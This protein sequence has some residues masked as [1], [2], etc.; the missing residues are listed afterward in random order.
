MSKLTPAVTT[1][2]LYY[3]WHFRRRNRIYIL[4]ERPKPRPPSWKHEYR[5][6]QELILKKFDKHSKIHMCETHGTARTKADK[7]L[8]Q[9]LK[10]QE[11]IY[12]EIVVNFALSFFDHFTNATFN[13]RHDWRNDGY[14]TNQLVYR[15]AFLRKHHILLP[16]PMI[17]KS[18][19]LVADV[20]TNLMPL[21]IVRSI[22]WNGL[23][24]NIASVLLLSATDKRPSAVNDGG[25]CCGGLKT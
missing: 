21:K 5:R 11:F 7:Y 12:V 18:L 8:C 10:I 23:T 17:D 2:M 1:T 3:Y 20:K 19:G 16:L 9:H 25:R 14:K 15:P 24:T 4:D 13:K 22:C 6:M